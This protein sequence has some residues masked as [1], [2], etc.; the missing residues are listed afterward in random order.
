MD[1]NQK[2]QA[3][4]LEPQTT[5]QITFDVTMRAADWSELSHHLGEMPLRVAQPFWKQIQNGLVVAAQ[6]IHN[7]NTQKNEEQTEEEKQQPVDSEE[8]VEKD[9]SVPESGEGG[10]EEQLPEKG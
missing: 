10:Q 1:N 8:Q 3:P 7:Q 4:L 6:Q 5:I 9:D 2:E